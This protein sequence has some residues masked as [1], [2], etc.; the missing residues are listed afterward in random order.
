MVFVE[1]GQLI[2]FPPSSSIGRT[3]PFNRSFAAKYGRTATDYV[4]S[5]TILDIKTK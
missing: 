4:G 1:R 5:G 3:V 2:S